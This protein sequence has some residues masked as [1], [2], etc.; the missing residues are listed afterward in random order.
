MHGVPVTYINSCITLNFLVED[1]SMQVSSL[2]K[3]TKVYMHK[4]HIW[5]ASKSNE[6]MSYLRESETY[7]TA[8]M[9]DTALLTRPGS[10]KTFF[11]H[12]YVRQP[13][14]VIFFIVYMLELFI[15]DGL[16]GDIIFM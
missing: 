7:S 3:Y 14:D 4:H 10:L 16:H 11:F 2:S 1:Y 13:Y 12:S 15:R 5:W 8:S 9:R 6:L